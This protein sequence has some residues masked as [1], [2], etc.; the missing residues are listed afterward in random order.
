[1][2]RWTITIA[3]LLLIV[4]LADHIGAQE[5]DAARRA[6][7]YEPLIVAA[8]IKH[9]VDPRLL[10][11]VAWLES[12]FQ[13]YVTSGAGAQGM[14]QFMPAT[15]WRY[16]LRD[17]FDPAQAVDAAARYL[18][19]LQE[20]FGRRLDLILAGYNAGEGAVRAFRTGRK[21]ILSDGRVINPKGIK[22]T[23]PPYRET[24][25]YVTNG[26]QVFGMLVRTGY[27]SDRRLARLRNIESPNEEEQEAL[28]T[29]DLEEAPEDIVDL[30]KGSV[31]AVEEIPFPPA[32]KSATHSVYIH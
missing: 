20:M 32:K 3:L 30:K 24:V 4:T 8:S 19:D 22:S 6:R 10:W 15:A 26:A 17:P 11:T 1:M 9:R 16:G 28:V 18:R 31:Y 27:F 25:N 5:V 7:L 13:P 23:I 14:M 2:R 21:L 29:V 12:G